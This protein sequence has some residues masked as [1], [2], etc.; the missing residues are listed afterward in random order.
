MQRNNHED[1]VTFFLFTVCVADLNGKTVVV[2][3]N[4]T[5]IF[6]LLLRHLETIDCKVLY[7]QRGATESI[8]I[9]AAYQVL[10]KDLSSLLMSLHCIA[11]L[12]ILQEKA[13]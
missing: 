10:H 8:I 5:D 6:V 12:E 1:R 3:A 2:H 4:D 13:S 7:M 11:R 9:P